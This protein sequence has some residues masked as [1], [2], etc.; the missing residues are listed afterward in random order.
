MYIKHWRSEERGRFKEESKKFRILNEKRLAALLNNFIDNYRSEISEKIF[1]SKMKNYFRGS[2]KNGVAL[3]GHIDGIF[4]V[5]SKVMVIRIDFGYRRSAEEL[6]SHRTTVKFSDVKTHREELLKDL[7]NSFKDSFIT[8]AWKLEYGMEKGYHYH[9]LFF[10]NGSKL[11]KDVTV[12]KII[13]D[14]WNVVTEGE[15]VYYN[16]N[17]S[18]GKY[19]HSCIGVLTCH[20]TERINALKKFVANYIVKVDHFVQLDLEIQSRTFGKGAIPR[21]NLNNVGRPRRK[22]D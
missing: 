18:K 4:R 8:Y 5:Y 3:R 12:A 6:V 10:F 14:K 9:F 13:G 20:D 16:C 22:L 1:K 7:R 19:I 2:K 15:G 21:S 11:R 17:G